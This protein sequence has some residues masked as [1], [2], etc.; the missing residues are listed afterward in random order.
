[1]NMNLP[2]AVQDA[3][4]LLSS[5][6]MAA[7]MDGPLIA[8]DIYAITVSLYTAVVISAYWDEILD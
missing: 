3:L 5:G 6:I 1:M 7:L 2:V 4:N 8:G